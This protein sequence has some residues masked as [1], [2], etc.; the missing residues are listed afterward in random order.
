MNAS[1]DS[2]PRSLRKLAARCALSFGLGLALLAALAHWSELH[3]REM[4]A[5]L[6]SL[7]LTAFLLALA[8]H[9]GIYLL[10]TW[11]FLLLLPQAP[12]PAFA[13]AFT[14]GAA[15]NLATYVLPAK[16]GEAAWVVYLRIYAGVPSAV[17][18]ASLLVARLLD[19]A[20]LCS[21][22]ACACFALRAG[23]AYPQ[24]AWLVPLGAALLAPAFG[25]ALLSARSEVCL[26]A[27]AAV[28][29]A[30]RLRRLAIGQRLFARLDEVAHALRE[31]SRGARLV[32]AALL[33][34]P[35]WLGIF[36]FYAV[37][38]RAMGLPAELGFA[39]AS[40]GSSLAVLTNLLPINGLAGFGTQEAG[41]VLGFGALGVPRDQAL[42]TGV[43]V[44]L[45]Q[46]A[47][48]LALGLLAHLAM[49]FMR[50]APQ[51]AA[52]GLRA[53]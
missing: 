9:V 1:P 44:H 18:L 35:Q 45:V 34:V 51:P 31:A 27:F 42:A 53:E 25:F 26:R 20:V 32:R 22:L 29:G 13:Q 40:F 37:L 41:W 33:T 8:I 11:R 36:A 49:G 5:E 7:P 10:R 3:P 17:G 28:L 21:L 16:T 24:L 15:H 4:L 19:L 38:A 6:R 14:L 43:G 52:R 47:D 2:Q 50:K 48:T 46:L 30:L 39:E 23:G 12:P